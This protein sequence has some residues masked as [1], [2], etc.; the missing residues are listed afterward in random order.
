M[1]SSG[2]IFE[3]KENRLA[4]YGQGETILLEPFGE[5]ILRFRATKGREIVEENWTLLPQKEVSANIIVDSNKAVIQ[6]GKLTAEVRVEGDI[7]YL[8]TFDGRILLEELWIDHRINNAEVLKARNYKALSSDLFKIQVYF[9]SFDDEHFYGMGQYAN[10]YLNLKG[11][12]LELA[13][14]NTQISIPFLLSSR[15]YG[16]VWNNP[17]I[18]RVELAKNHTMWLAEAARQIDY[19]VIAGDTPAEIVKKYTNLVGKAPPMPEW[20][21][22]FWQCKLRYRSQDELLSIARE[23][24]RRNLPLSVIVIDF[25]HWTNQG[26]WKF[27]PKY[28]PDPKKM[29]EELESMG[30]KVMVSIWPTVD[31]NSEN[32]DEMVRR[33]LLVR[34]EKGIP[35]V[36]TFRGFTTY[37]DFTNPETR[38]FVWEKVKEN[39]YK[40]GIKAF[41]LDEAEPQFGMRGLGYDNVLPYDYDNIRYYLGNGLEVS[42]LYPFYYAK[43]FH[44]GLK[45]LGED[46]F[47]LI[48]AAWH[49]S[50]RF[51]IVVWSGDIP[52]TFD[53][54]RRQIKAGLNMAI[55]GITW[56]TTDIGGFYGGD[57]RDPRFQELIIRWFQFG[58]FCPIFRLHGFRLPY[59]KDP[60]KCDSYELT[61]GPNE[62]WSFGERAYKILCDFLFIRERLKPY[63]IEQMKICCEEGVPLMRP[64]FFDF[65]FDENTYDIEDEF[66]FGSDILV[67]PVYEEGAKSRKVY[68]PKRTKWTDAWNSNVYEGGQWINRA[69]PLEIIPIFLREGAKISLTK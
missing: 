7:R 50:Q 10:G 29:V 63:I 2:M 27:D 55:C 3:A 11:C 34:T 20:A 8:N 26:D 59:P 43:A 14:K 51:N 48:R 57:P 30:V 21:L 40:Y 16:F 38:R 58:C 47:L 67:A 69:T 68:L 54:L 65:P 39:Y 49:G 17:S 44:E 9:K 31:V 25:F 12:V 6:N 61:G 24:K 56:W 18:G 4:I 45:S 19:I 42:N 66:M 52:S 32:Y 60:N 23:Y 5:D 28:W 37:C 36:F 33:G 62:V 46:D 41:W 1:R 35:I 53:S 13:H 64:L 15:G 22:G